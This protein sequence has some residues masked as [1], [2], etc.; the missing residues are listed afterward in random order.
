MLNV[1]YVHFCVKNIGVEPQ[2]ILA[3]SINLMLNKFIGFIIV[4]TI[5]LS[6]SSTGGA[7]WFVNQGQ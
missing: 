2:R 4:C 5:T 7:N 3:I 6:H 1:V